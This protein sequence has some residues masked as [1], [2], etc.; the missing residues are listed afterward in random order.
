M[1][2]YTFQNAC[3]SHFDCPKRYRR[4]G[5]YEDQGSAEIVEPRSEVEENA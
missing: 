1:K 4:E 5:S 2:H 3:I